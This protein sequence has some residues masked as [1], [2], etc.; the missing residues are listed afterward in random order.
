MSGSDP[1]FL[2]VSVKQIEGE[3]REPRTGG[4]PAA[5]QA[6]KV[7]SPFCVWQHELAIDDCRTT[8]NPLQGVCD[9]NEPPG[10]IIAAAAVEPHV[11][12]F[13]DDLQPVTVEFGSCTQSKRRA[14]P[15]WGRDCTEQ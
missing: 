9:C 3:H 2:A 14:A 1:Q 11:A 6:G 15:R 12:A 10:P 8:G 4:S 5:V 7:G 13:L